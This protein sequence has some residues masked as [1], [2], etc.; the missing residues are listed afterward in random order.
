LNEIHQPGDQADAEQANQRKLD[1]FR[2]RVIHLS[3][4]V[5]LF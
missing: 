1:E 5:F 2:F 4:Y 3:S